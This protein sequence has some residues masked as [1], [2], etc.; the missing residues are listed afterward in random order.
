[1]N[2]RMILAGAAAA[3]LGGC[4][5]MN[6]N[7]ASQS[8]SAGMAAGPTAAQVNNCR[9]AEAGA[10]AGTPGQNCDPVVNSNEPR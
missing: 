9:P 5:G 3:A 7:T 4:A 6:D 2:I 10:P 1:M 8:N